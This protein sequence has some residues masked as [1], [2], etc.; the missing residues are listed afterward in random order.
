MNEERLEQAIYNNAVW[1][2]T[3]CRAHGSPGEFLEGIWIS[4]HRAPPFFPNAVTLAREPVTTQLARVQALVDA[5]IPGDWGVK[6]SYCALDL[7]SLGFR[8][9]FEAEWISRPAS[10]PR[11]DSDIPGVRWARVARV[12]QLAHWEMAWRGKPAAEMARNQ[13][14]I[15]LPPLL[16]DGNVTI[17]AAYRDRR[18]VAGAVASRTGSVTGVSN[19]FL[20]VR[21]RR[22][23]RASCIAQVMDAFPGLP[24]VGYE[25]GDDLAEMQDLGFEAL[26]PLGV[27][28]KVSKKPGFSE[29]TRFLPHS[30]RE[31]RHARSSPELWDAPSPDRSCP[32]RHRGV[33]HPSAR[34][35]SLPAGRDGRWATP[36]GHWLW[37]AGLYRAHALYAADDGPGRLPA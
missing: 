29:K 15:F 22:R 32:R 14:R 24:L 16:R 9:L 4:R 35:D 27:W 10:R 1:C 11:P 36:G 31:R 18:I 8:I 21:E 17:I 34:G 33:A 26:G 3:V 25:A 28:V 13:G 6:D 30:R 5:G 20:P 19:V 7:S 12:S 37:D 23:F 2:D